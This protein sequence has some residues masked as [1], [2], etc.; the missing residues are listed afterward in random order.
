MAATVPS[1][2][3]SITTLSPALSQD[4]LM[5]KASGQHA[6]PG[7]QSLALLGQMIGEPGQRIVRMPEHV[8]AGATTGFGAV[9]EGAAGHLQQVGC[10][11]RGRPG[12]ARAGG[13][14]I[15]GDQSRRAQR[16]PFE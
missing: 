5:H 3:S 4:G 14:E 13:E 15:V 7:V 2:S 9:D 10:L 16:L 8:G 12:R 6:L 1:P 11:V